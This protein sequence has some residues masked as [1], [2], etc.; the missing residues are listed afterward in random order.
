MSGQPL[1]LFIG[2]YYEVQRF[3]H[4]QLLRQIKAE[5]YVFRAEQRLATLARH[6]GKSLAPSSATQ[7]DRTGRSRAARRK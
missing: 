1:D 3:K 2:K 5:F 7:P 6:H 4:A